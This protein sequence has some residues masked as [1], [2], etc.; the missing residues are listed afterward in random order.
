MLQKKD[1]SVTMER[2]SRYN[3]EILKFIVDEVEKHP[4]DIAS[5]T[6]GKFKTTR[7]TAHRYLQRLIGDGTISATGETK[8]RRYQLVNFV[9]QAFEI[10]IND[11]TEEHLVFRKKIAPLLDGLPKNIFEMFE[12][13]CS[14]MINNVKDHSQSKKATIAVERNAKKT[15]VIIRDYGIGI[16]KKIKDECHLNDEREAILELSKGKLTTAPDKHT[17]EGIFFTSRMC[18]YFRILSGTL[19]YVHEMTFDDDFLMEADTKEQN[20]QG[21]AVTLEIDTDAAYTVSEIFKKYETDQDGYGAFTKTHVPVR[22]ALYGNEQLVSRSQ[23]RRVLARFNKFSEVM[24]DFKDVPRIG[25][26]FADEVFRVYRNEHP[27][28][29][30]IPIRTSDEVQAMIDRVTSGKD[31]TQADLFQAASNP[32]TDN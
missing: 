24:L 13:G 20:L 31:V 16:F 2:K 9:D 3:P 23:A 29:K 27:E 5:V 15:E 26:A 10:E 25:Q 4:H 8:A 28:V 19:A 12:Y 17:G 32:S 14:E 1:R 21:T 7:M 30:I 18:K 6:A 22:L 11:K